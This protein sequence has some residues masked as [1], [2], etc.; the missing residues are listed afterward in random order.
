LLFLDQL[1]I[2]TLGF[3]ASFNISRHLYRFFKQFIKTS[4]KFDHRISV[5]SSQVPFTNR[6]NYLLVLP[7]LS[8]NETFIPGSLLDNRL[9]LRLANTIIAGIAKEAPY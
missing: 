2:Y 3:D 9:S 1:S 6:K 5:L 7:C 8:K 4:Q